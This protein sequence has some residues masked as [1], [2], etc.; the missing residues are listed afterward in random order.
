MSQHGYMSH[1]ATPPLV[2][3]LIRLIQ[4][5]SCGKTIKNHLLIA[6]TAKSAN[7]NLMTRP[8][9]RWS[10]GTRPSPRLRLTPIS[11]YAVSL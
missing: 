4:S 10:S 3:D 11:R 6:N 1:T 8:Q 5:G 2:L 9:L 7:N